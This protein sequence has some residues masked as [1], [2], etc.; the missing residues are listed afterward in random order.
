MRAIL[1]DIAEA[2]SLASSQTHELAGVL[3]VLA[4]PVLATHVI[5]PM[6]ADFRLLHPKILLNIEVD[7]FKEPNRGLRHH[8]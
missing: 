1:Q 8:P 2:D 4:P 3:R 5:A 7:S 6:I